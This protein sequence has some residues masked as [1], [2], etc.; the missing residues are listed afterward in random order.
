MNPT[1]LT[2]YQSP[3]P[4]IRIGK[5][6]DG[7]YIVADV[8]NAKYDLLLAG[9]IDNDISFEEQFLTKYETSRC[10]AFDGTI[11]SAP[12]TNPKIEYVCRN[13]GG[14]NEGNVSDLHDILDQ[15]QNIFVKM[16]IEGHEIPWYISLKDEHMNK[17]EQIVMEFHWPFSKVEAAVFAKINRTH[18]L[19][20]FHPNNC[21]GVSQHAGVWIPNI[22]EV[23]YLH[24]RHFASPPALSTDPIPGPLDMKNTANPDIH[25][26]YPPFVHPRTQ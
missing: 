10:L 18:H 21:L 13:I 9:G 19:I 5:D 3:F 15:Y 23:T 11:T 6:G 2:V 14:V 24:K 25:I 17:L 7:G 26:N 20:H 12:T 4:K 16:D 22:F 1:L 8:P